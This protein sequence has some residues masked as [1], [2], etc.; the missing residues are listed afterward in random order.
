MIVSKSE[1]ERAAEKQ[2]MS[3]IKRV[4]RSGR[5]SECENEYE[6]LRS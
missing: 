4:I 3:M 6:K 5:R 2:N 1:T